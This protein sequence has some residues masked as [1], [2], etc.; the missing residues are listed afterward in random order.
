MTVAAPEKL[1]PWTT[2]KAR[3]HYLLFAG[4]D[5]YPA[6]GVLDLKLTFQ[7]LDGAAAVSIAL[8]WVAQQSDTPLADPPD[9][10]ELHHVGPAG[11]VLVEKA[12]RL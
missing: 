10:W 9:W 5:Y 8:D 3:F 7:A 4:S 11:L 12:G 1:E 2:S 6:G